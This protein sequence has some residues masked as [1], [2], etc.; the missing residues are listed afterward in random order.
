MTE[1]CDL[2]L[3]F[4]CSKCLGPFT[5]IH[6]LQKSIFLGAQYLRFARRGPFAIYSKMSEGSPCQMSQIRRFVSTRPIG[7]CV[8]GGQ[9]GLLIFLSGQRQ[10]LTAFVPSVSALHLKNTRLG[11]PNLVTAQFICYFQA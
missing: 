7:D 5:V 8:S 2:V 10:A 9:A 4:V 6:S 3:Y 11:L 1:K